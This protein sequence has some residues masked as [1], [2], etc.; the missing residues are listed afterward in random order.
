MKGVEDRAGVW[1]D[2]DTILRP[3]NVEIERRHDGRERSARGLVTADFQT[4]FVL[5]QVIRVM[6]HPDRKPENLA[7]ES[8]KHLQLVALGRA[9]RALGHRSQLLRGLFTIFGCDAGLLVRCVK[10]GLAGGG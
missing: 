1:L 6:D 3:Q 10:D 4:V 5:A 8:T 2:R 9:T 7:L